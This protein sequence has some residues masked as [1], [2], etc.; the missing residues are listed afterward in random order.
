MK[1]II[2]KIEGLLVIMG[3][4]LIT[5]VIVFIPTEL[6]L[7]ARVTLQPEGFW[8]ELI[9][10]GIA[11]YFLLGIQFILIIIGAIFLFEVFSKTK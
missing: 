4:I 9:L 5:L 3:I 7:F 6:Y 10:T 2:D 11:L 1:K 8:Q